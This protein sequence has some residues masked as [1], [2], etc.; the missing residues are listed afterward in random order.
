MFISQSHINVVS[1]ALESI[2]HS[3]TDK[4]GNAMIRF[5]YDD[6]NLDLEKLLMS[7][8]VSAQA[9]SYQWQTW[10]NCFC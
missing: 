4:A 10:E 9:W 2:S 6:Q 1:K 7:P 3:A 8:L 5:G